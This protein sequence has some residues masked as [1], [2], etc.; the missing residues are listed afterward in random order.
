MRLMYSQI[1][2]FPAKSQWLLQVCR[3]IVILTSLNSVAMCEF[4]IMPTAEIVCANVPLCSIP[5][6]ES[7]GNNYK[8]FLNNA[9]GLFLETF[10]M[11]LCLSLSVHAFLHPS[12]D[13]FSA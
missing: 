11:L 8:V 1:G 7:H 6:W 10:S 5:L 12:S 9:A 4:I 3:D 2:A 13:T